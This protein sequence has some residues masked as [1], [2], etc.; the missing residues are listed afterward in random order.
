MTILLELID[1]IL[2]EKYHIEKQLGQGGMGAV[3]LATHI[4]TKRPVALKVIAPQFMTNIEFV[5]RFKRESEAAGRLRHPNVVNVTDFGF[6]DVCGQRVAYLVMEYLD[7]CSLGDLLKK[8]GRLPLGF[9]VDIAEQVC[10]AIDKAHRQ[11]IIHRDLKPDNIWLEP[12]GRGG[13]NVKVLDFG[14]A[15]LRHSIPSGLQ[16][17]TAVSVPASSS[18]ISSERNPVELSAIT[19]AQPPGVDLEACTQVQPAGN[20]DEEKTQVA[21]SRATQN[22]QEIRTVPA[23]GLTQAGA[24]LG[25]PLYM[26][27]EQ[28]KGEQLD[29]RSDIYSLGVIV[30]QMLAGETPF[31]GDMFT[32]IG[33][34]T[35]EMP[36]SLKAAR[37]DIPA[38][39][40]AV[41]MSALAKSPAERPATAEAFATSLSANAEGES[42]LFF[43]ATEIYRKNRFTFFYLSA[44]LYSLCAILVYS[45]S[46]INIW[47]ISFALLL[48]PF[49][50]TLNTAGC[51]LI[52]QQIRSAPSSSIRL[53]SILSALFKRLPALLGAAI[54]NSLSVLFGSLKL[55]KPGLRAYTDHSLYAPVVIL[56][57]KQGKVALARSKELVNRL[58]YPHVSTQLHE[59]LI[60][61]LI[62][63]FFVFAAVY[64]FHMLDVLTKSWTPFAMVIAIIITIL[65]SS[66]HSR[67]AIAFSLLY[68]RTL[69]AG[70]E[71]LS[72]R[73]VQEFELEDP[74][75]LPR[76]SYRQTAGL[77]AGLFFRQL[78]GIMAG[79]L[80]AFTIS[81]MVAFVLVLGVGGLDKNL[82]YMAQLGKTKE[83]TELLNKGVDINMK[84]GLGRTALIAAAADG[85]TE[86]MKILIDRGADMNIKGPVGMTA[87]TAAATLGR[88][89]A[90]R[91]LLERGADVNVRNESNQTALIAAAE[92][93]HADIVKML[94][95]AGSDPNVKD[96]SGKSALMYAEQEQH[97][98][99][100]EILKSAGTQ[101]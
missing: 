47:L 7:G 16:N 95:T 61:F 92:K 6:A 17:E 2:D 97:S 25:T 18:L 35:Q 11:E 34:H 12:N 89:E 100:V 5:E 51:A 33:K 57:D 70:G 87:L 64:L 96:K 75:G 84:D 26:S 41:V 60:S 43:Q 101:P 54:R 38:S 37:T 50:N 82:V 1:Q 23:E 90:V 71:K 39:V 74:P 46:F 78:I 91:I 79:V 49:F 24:V 62:L 20:S 63:C 40:A 45:L 94:L 99:I 32:L 22:R 72:E 80:V 93:G 58:R 65:I 66:T 9:V 67:Y 73:T 69:Q 48:L 85:R 42:P 56:E 68:Y 13:Y 76:Q 3:Y 52:V 27:P 15:K 10:L 83:V 21:G 8:K 86:I 53:R 59:L 98:E 36:V 14:L 31:N 30:Y 19:M 28:C 55:V 81:A 29:A 4:G 44:L 88:T 77:L